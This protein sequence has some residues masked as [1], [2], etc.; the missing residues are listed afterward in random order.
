MGLK[1]R[2]RGSDEAGDGCSGPCAVTGLERG[3]W[4]EG[5]IGESPKRSRMVCVGDWAGNVHQS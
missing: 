4:H 1:L 3:T 2:A 5:G